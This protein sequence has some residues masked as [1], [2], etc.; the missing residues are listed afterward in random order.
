MGE[1]CGMDELNRSRARWRKST[2]STGR[3]VAVRSGFGAVGGVKHPDVAKLLRAWQA[4]VVGVREAVRALDAATACVIEY[5][6]LIVQTNA[7]GPAS[8]WRLA[9]HAMAE[10]SQQ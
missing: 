4:L 1:G 6:A 9:C 2:L 10:Q 8:V 7:A 3:C 5:R